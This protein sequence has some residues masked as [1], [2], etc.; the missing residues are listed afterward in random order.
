M[1]GLWP[2]P[3][4]RDINTYF[5]RWSIDQDRPVEYGD[6]YVIKEMILHDMVNRKT[7][8]SNPILNVSHTGVTKLLDMCG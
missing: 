1:H 3:L 6:L 2:L 5:E 7:T 8:I 4:A